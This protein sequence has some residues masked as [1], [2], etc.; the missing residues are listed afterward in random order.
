MGIQSHGR[1]TRGLIMKELLKPI[2]NFILIFAAV[3]C[4]MGAI[5]SSFNFS[6]Y[7]ITALL[8][9]MVTIIALVV[10][11]HFARLRGILILLLFSLI[12]LYF[13]WTEIFQGAKWAIYHISSIFNVWLFVPVLFPE[14]EDYSEYLTIFLIAAGVFQS[15]LL[16]IAVCIKRSTVLTI[17]FT[18]PFV[19]ITFV[20]VFNS[21]HPIFLVG[22]LAI[23]L[24]MLISS[25]IEPDS[26]EKRSA[27]VYP[28]FLLVAV[29][30]GIG[31]VI[32]P[33]GDRAR[34]DFIRSIDYTIREAAS[35][36]GLARVRTGVGWPVAIDDRWGFN[37][38]HVDISSAGTRV[39][40]D[41]SIFEAVSDTP[42]VFYLRGYSMQYFDGNTWTVNSEDLEIS[43]TDRLI[44]SVPASFA[45]LYSWR[46]WRFPGSRPPDSVHMQI[47]I[48]GDV[49]DG[50]IY[51]PYF[52]FPMLHADD[53][54][55]FEFFYLR[56]SL[57]RIVERVSRDN[58][59]ALD[60]T[61]INPI[62]E[63]FSRLV[64]SPDTY[65]QINELAAERLRAFA[66]TAG[67]DANATRE[68]IANQVAE[69]MIDFGTYTLAPFIIP[70][71]DDF[72]M[73]FLERSRQGFC[74][75]YA[76][77]ATMM[78]RALGIPA[79]FTSGFIV[80]VAPSQIGETL[81]ITDRYA[82]AW[83]EVFFDEVGWLPIE[84]TPPATGFGEGDGRPGLNAINPFSP[85]GSYLD[86]D[87]LFL[88][89][90]W[91][92]ELEHGDA[93]VPTPGIGL[94]AAE[95]SREQRDVLRAVLIS[96]LAALL[97]ASP[98]IHRAAIV[99]LRSKYFKQED[100]N[101]SVIYA[102]RYLCKLNRFRSM[103]DLSAEVEDLAL[104]ARYS[105]HTITEDER[106]SVV[107]YAASYAQRV[108]AYHSPLKKFWLKY[109]R[110]L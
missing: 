89:D 82:H 36:M 24:T 74:I 44:R 31:A 94:G 64:H 20:L 40:H 56:E 11:A 81:I 57:L 54:Y 97:I 12:L 13:N 33:P 50:I 21:S 85:V 86:D 100:T 46:S 70:M 26:F 42:G 61:T 16:S 68:Q 91:W 27:A 108:F 75:H 53:T 67:I 88:F 14:A 76:T 32:A 18:A 15:F 10:N 39:I 47:S 79:R 92:D 93:T 95:Q 22:L 28:A 102:W 49:S 90:P 101:A 43:E 45:N 98:F 2:G 109:I 51:H 7:A 58:A 55:E 4:T 84:V 1:L 19:I 29:V 9:W 63:N 96:L 41:V 107:T 34:A 87:D 60:L 62:L 5:V 30:M 8:V 104:K 77:A 52:S 59:S 25:G 48:T 69:F 17:L 110:G 37:T 73:H 106:L 3:L 105:K 23:Y 72:V 38:D 35:R 99:R 6:I 78:L 66:Y 65:L 71:D 83:V 80:T 103:E